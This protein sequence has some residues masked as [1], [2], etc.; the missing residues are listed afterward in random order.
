MSLLIQ[1][2]RPRGRSFVPDYI[3]DA[4]N[5][6]VMGATT[7]AQATYNAANNGNVG[8][9]RRPTNSVQYVTPSFNGFKDQLSVQH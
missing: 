3:G 6:T 2:H 5:I 1:T 7:A 8:W 9:E 4:R